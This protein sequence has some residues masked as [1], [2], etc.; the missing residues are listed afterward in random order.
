MKT[1][2][3]KH[4]EKIDIRMLSWDQLRRISMRNIYSNPFYGKEYTCRGTKQVFGMQ[5]KGQQGFCYFCGRHL[6]FI[7]FGISAPKYADLYEVN[8]T[9]PD[10]K[11]YCRPL[12]FCNEK[13][14]SAFNQEQE[15]R[16]K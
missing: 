15:Q 1:L 13:C 12:V 16:Q 14:F 5:G 9:D 7:P 11:T 3:K 4:P 10:Q 2:K 6:D 8:A